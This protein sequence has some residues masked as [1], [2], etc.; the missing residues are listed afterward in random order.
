MSC[1]LLRELKSAC[2]HNLM[3]IVHFLKDGGQWQS[4]SPVYC[5]F[6]CTICKVEIG[7]DDSVV[8]LT[9]SEHVD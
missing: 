7:V 9:I 2:R 8:I 1:M 6:V 3:H 5:R 4:H